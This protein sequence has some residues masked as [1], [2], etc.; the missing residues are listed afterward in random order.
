MENFYFLQS[1]KNTI[2]YL[3]IKL[4]FML[5]NTNALLEILHTQN[6]NEINIENAIF[7]LLELNQIQKAEKELEKNKDKL[8][9]SSYEILKLAFVQPYET[10]YLEISSI[11]KKTFFSISKPEINKA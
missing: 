2:Q 1:S 6:L 9:K 5:N 11:L 7:C 8:K 4:S 10:A 3:S